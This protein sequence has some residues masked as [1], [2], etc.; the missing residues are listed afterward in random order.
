MQLLTWT[1]NPSAA[2]AIA[3]RKEEIYDGLMNG[4]A[5][6]EV[7]GVRAFLEMLANFNVRRGPGVGWGLGGWGGG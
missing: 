5:P 6:A 3:K 1:R 7:P 2:A 4:V